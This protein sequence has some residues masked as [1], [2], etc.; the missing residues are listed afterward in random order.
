MPIAIAV[1]GY[2]GGAMGTAHVK[3]SERCW[4]HDVVAR[5]L[6][7]LRHN[8]VTPASVRNENDAG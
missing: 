2:H 3:K 7:E 8:V 5:A 1:P 4:H 6:T